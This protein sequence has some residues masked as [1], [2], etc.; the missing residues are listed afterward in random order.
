MPEPP[1]WALTNHNRPSGQG[2]FAGHGERTIGAL[3]ARNRGQT[4]E[5]AENPLS[6]ANDYDQLIQSVWIEY[7]NGNA[8]SAKAALKAAIAAAR[9]FEQLH[10]AFPFVPSV[11][12]DWERIRL[13]LELEA[14]LNSASIGQPDVDDPGRSVLAMRL[15]IALR[16]YD[17]FQRLLHQAAGQDGIWMGRLRRLSKSLQNRREP[18]FSAQKVF[19]IGLS[20]SGTTSLMRAMETL[21]FH[22][23][24]WCNYFTGE[25]LTLDDALLFDALGD[26][27]VCGFFESL[28]HSFPNSKFIYT[29]RSIDSWLA[30]VERF[31]EAW[32]PTAGPKANPVPLTSNYGV[33]S[34]LGFRFS[35]VES[36]AWMSP[37][38]LIS[39][40]EA[41]EARVKTF[42]DAYDQTRLLE[43]N[44][45][46]GDGWEK[47]CGFLKRA[48]PKEPFPH[49]NRTE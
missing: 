32:L 45:F 43:F 7:S 27:P 49:E 13:W 17:G 5:L 37:P 38:D 3:C 25:I 40:R 39:A 9:T 28:Y 11:A 2:V 30:S 46:S 6:D 4:M 31:N 19:G 24:H 26:I 41:F 34:S 44:L 22:A 35:V 36:S 20:K 10:H 21:G 29:S 14:R 48:V 23:A 42:F 33:G 12:E 15:K 18:D 1:E 8:Q 16:D 47:L